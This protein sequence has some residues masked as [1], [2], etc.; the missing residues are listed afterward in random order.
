MRRAPARPVRACLCAAGLH[1]SKGRAWRSTL[2]TA[3]FKLHTSH[4]AL[5]LHTPNFISSHLFSPHLSSS[6]LISPLLFS[7]V[8]LSSS[9][10]FSFHLSNAQPFSSHRSLPQL[11]SALLRVTGPLLSERLLRAD[12]FCTEKTLHT[13]VWDAEV[14]DGSVYEK[15]LHTAFFCT[16][17]L[18]HR[19]TFTH[20]SCYTQ[21]RTFYVPVC[22][23][24]SQ[25]YFV[26]R[27]L[28]KE[29][30]GTASY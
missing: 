15:L 20:R 16:E 14:W 30:P 28:D 4:I 8:H 10:L 22:A 26:L 5:T 25:Y 29:L 27:S 6:H 21:N 7:Y 9:E 19:E 17:K 2:H 18:L 13:E 24:I 1:C 23:N 3:L 11:I 12:R